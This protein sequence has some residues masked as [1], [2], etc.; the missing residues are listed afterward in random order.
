MLRPALPLRTVGLELVG[1]LP[2]S[3]RQRVHDTRRRVELVRDEADLDRRLARAAELFGESDDRAR[4]YLASF[5]M[6]AP[7][8]PADP[9]SP[10][11]AEAQWD[12]YRRVSRRDGYTV[13]HEETDVELSVH[14]LSPYPYSTGS[15]RQVAAQLAATSFVLRRLDPRPGQRVVEFGA[16][17]GNLTLPIAMLGAEVTAVEVGRGLAE[18]LRRRAAGLTTLRVVESDMLGFEREG[19]PY[20]VALFFESFHHCAD[21]LE[22]LC[23]LRRI[24]T[25]GGRLAF[26]AEPVARLAYPWG[27]RL[28]GLSLW[29]TRAYGWLELGFDTG[30]FA[31]ALARTGWGRG[32]R[33]RSRSLGPLADVIVVTN[34]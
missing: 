4:G 16:G 22:M 7:P 3:I 2:D 30:Y 26:A 25:T 29:S 10:A 28:D 8:M 32:A 34:L 18:I 27:L 24:V 9:F 15:A 14:T 17:W 20:D 6:E 33:H 31:E 13:T 21:H 12:L 1:V 23:R 19:E 5:R 11:Y